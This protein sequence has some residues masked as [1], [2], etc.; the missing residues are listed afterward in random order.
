MRPLKNLHLTSII[1]L[2]MGKL[3]GTVTSKVH[4]QVAQTRNFL[5]R[6]SFLP[7]SAPPSR[8]SRDIGNELESRVERMFRQSGQKNVKRNVILHDRYGNVSE[9]DLI[10]GGRFRKTYVECKNY[11]GRPVPLSDV[12][13]FKEVLQLNNIPIEKFAP[14]PP[15]GSNP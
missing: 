4:K 3:F 7:F 10:C 11:S 13:K 12:A 5:T 9:V 8:T 2:S 15:P 6:P 1:L 14:P